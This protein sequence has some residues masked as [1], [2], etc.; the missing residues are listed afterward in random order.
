M[1]AALTCTAALTVVLFFMPDLPL[2]L[3]RGVGA[4][5]AP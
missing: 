3:A 2:E 4:R 5:T 1:V